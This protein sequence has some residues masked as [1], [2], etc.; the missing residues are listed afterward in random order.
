[1]IRNVHENATGH[2]GD[3]IVAGR[4]AVVVEKLLA[5][6]RRLPVLGRP[7]RLLKAA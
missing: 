1:M 5:S 3:P 7:A 4:C 2:L 6:R